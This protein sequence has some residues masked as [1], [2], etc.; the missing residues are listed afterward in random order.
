MFLISVLYGFDKVFS[1][2]MVFCV[3]KYV[4]FIGITIQFIYDVRSF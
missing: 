1:S 4:S 3:I 2:W